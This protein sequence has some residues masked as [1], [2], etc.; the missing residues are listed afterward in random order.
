[1]IPSGE[2]YDLERGQRKTLKDYSLHIGLSLGDVQLFGEK[3]EFLSLSDLLELTRK[4][5]LYGLNAHVYAGELVYRLLFSFMPFFGSLS[6]LYLFLRFRELGKVLL[7][8][9]PLSVLLW[10]LVLAPKMITQKAN[11]GSALSLLPALLL[12]LLSLKGVNDL[13]K[14]FRV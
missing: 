9:V 3:T 2:L 11:Q 10:V 4:A 12:L 1:R 5:Q 8:F 13:R 7:F 14:G 6:V